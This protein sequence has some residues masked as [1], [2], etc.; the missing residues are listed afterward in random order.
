VISARLA[1]LYELDTVYGVAD[2][3]RLAEV[4]KVDAFNERI[5]HRWQASKRGE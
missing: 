1:T 3:Y 5:G 2:L 4:I